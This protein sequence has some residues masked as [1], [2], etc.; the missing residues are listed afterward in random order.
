VGIDTD[1]T[2]HSSVRTDIMFDE[3]ISICNSESPLRVARNT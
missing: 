3:K 1:Y 2:L